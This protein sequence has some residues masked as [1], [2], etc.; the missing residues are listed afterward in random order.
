MALPASAPSVSVARTLEEPRAPWPYTRAAVVVAALW[1]VPAVIALGQIS[2][3]QTLAGEPVAWRL[4]LWTTLPN[5]LLWALLTPPVVWLAARVGPQEPVWQ[6]VTA[7][8]AGAAV[9][10][11]VHAAGNVAAFRFAGLPSD[12]TLATFETH[13]AL[14]F[15][16]NVVA[17]GLIVASTWVALAMA[18]ARERERRQAV[19]EADLAQAELRA[20]KM[21]V[22]PHF[23]F[24]ALH[25]VGATVRKGEADQA[26][27]MLGQ[28]GD[29]LRS[30]FETDGA[31]EVPLAREVDMLD[32]YLALENV[33]VGPRLTVMWEVD[34]AARAVRVP[35]WTLQPLVENAVKHAV[36]SHSG[37][38]RITVRA[39]VEGGRLR[40]AVEDDG[41][42][43]ESEANIGLRPS[44]G[45]GL[46]NTRARLHA[47]Y[48]DAATL[49]LRPRDGGG[50]V[51]EVVLPIDP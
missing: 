43:A 42:G 2:I 34:E 37:P 46:A 35:A 28:L 32:R 51:A 9:A 25:A 4:A 3:E 39:A 22:R 8:V 41:P 38:A 44:T 47:L 29:L 48:G 21:Q 40:L 19:L 10:L 31:T 17:Y 50:T 30:S 24:N 5:W 23:L 14:R 12:W 16:V 33:R 13:Y 49:A 45:V 26:V 18:R 1:A 15:P 7:H 36:A 6:I 11:G 27:T 20:L